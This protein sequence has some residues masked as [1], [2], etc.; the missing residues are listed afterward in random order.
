MGA[1]VTAR[2]VRTHPLDSHI[3]VPGA[4]QASSASCGKLGV[5]LASQGMSGQRCPSPLFRQWGWGPRPMLPLSGIS[6][7]PWQGA[8]VCGQSARV[9]P[10]L[11]V[12]SGHWPVPAM[13]PLALPGCCLRPGPLLQVSVPGPRGTAAGPLDERPESPASE[14]GWRLGLCL[15]KDPEPSE[16]SLQPAERARLPQE[17]TGSLWVG[18]SPTFGKAY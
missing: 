18:A 9:C 3:L 10:T 8:L 7:G 14:C 11:G 1:S 5:T 16:T 4:P 2:L 17:V 6:K 12:T 13:A 15:E